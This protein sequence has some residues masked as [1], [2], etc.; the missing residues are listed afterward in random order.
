MSVCCNALQS[1]VN[2]SQRFTNGPLNASPMNPTLSQQFHNA[3][4]VTLHYYSYF[5]KFLSCRYDIEI[6]FNPFPTANN[7]CVMVK[8]KQKETM[9]LL[10]RV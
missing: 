9:E 10:P 7:Y 5:G 2:V 3:L 4:S 8:I 6:L 1:I